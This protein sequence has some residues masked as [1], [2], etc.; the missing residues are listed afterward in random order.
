M[1]LL[2]HFISGSSWI[3]WLLKAVAFVAVYGALLIVYGFNDSEKN[4]LFGKFFGII[5]RKEKI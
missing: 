4:V 2:S 5:G 3:I 1:I